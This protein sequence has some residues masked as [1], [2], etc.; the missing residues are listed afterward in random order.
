MSVGRFPARPGASGGVPVVGGAP[1]AGGVGVGPPG[2]GPGSRTRRRRG[3]RDRRRGRRGIAGRA[4]AGRD[5]AAGAG[6]LSAVGEGVR[7]E[8]GDE[9]ESRETREEGPVHGRGLSRPV[10]RGPPPG[11][12]RAP[13]PTRST[14][15]PSHAR[16][17]AVSRGSRSSRGMRP[18]GPNR[19]STASP[20]RRAPGRGCARDRSPAG[21][22]SRARNASA[23]RRSPR[24]AL[25]AGNV[26]VRGCHRP[27]A[28]RGATRDPAGAVDARRVP[29]TDGPQAGHVGPQRKRLSWKIR[30]R[31]PSKVRSPP[32][33]RTRWTSPR[34]GFTLTGRSQPGD[35][36]AHVLPRVP[37]LRVPRR[38]SRGPRA[39]R[40]RDA[41][42]PGAAGGAV[43]GRRGA[44]RGAL[45]DRGA[46]RR[47]RRGRRRPRRARA[48]AGSGG[49]A[50]SRG[51]AHADGR[52]RPRLA[53]PRGWRRRRRGAEGTRWRRTA[54]AAARR[55][56]AA[57]RASG[58]GAARV[59]ARRDRGAGAQGRRGCARV[60][61]GGRRRP[62]ARRR[63]WAR[64]LPF[65][66]A[67]RRAAGP[68]LRERGSREDLDRTRR[69]G[70][71]GVGQVGLGCAQARASAR[72]PRPCGGP[73]PGAPGR[74]STGLA[75][76]RAASRGD[77][78]ASGDPRAAQDARARA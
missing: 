35:P 43:G 59:G 13:D 26:G 34:R 31:G 49:A 52:A 5:A 74:S 22:T 57:A 70:H 17:H 71:V 42:P 4:E 58:R 3:G 6:E 55:R 45:R 1:G 36:H 25:P 33:R 63:A 77:G 20:P 21:A 23:L 54:D 8:D 15:A 16:C 32:T 39:R 66:P 27:C 41:R 51:A 19:T 72:S 11:S 78:A 9:E 53:L 76:R 12:R 40:R 47:V 75:H 65:R 44:G 28:S 69:R 56:S 60:P 29:A 24:G 67:A 30:V 73:A 2:V 14:G 64:G 37:R 62:R 48:R 7:G 38:A 68:C 46:R 18:T 50:G 10:R 61:E